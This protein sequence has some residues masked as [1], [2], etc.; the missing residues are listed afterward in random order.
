MDAIKQIRSLDL[1][2]RQNLNPQQEE[3]GNVGFKRY[4]GETA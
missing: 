1:A 2:T 4:G 3:D